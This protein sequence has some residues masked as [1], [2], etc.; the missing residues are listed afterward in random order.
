MRSLYPL[1]KA[2]VWSEGY[3]KAD[4]REIYR[5]CMFEAKET[6]GWKL[7]TS[8]LKVQGRQSQLELEVKEGKNS[9]KGT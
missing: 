7:M 2:S 9:D 4:V 3:V 8:Y 6:H 5:R 1:T